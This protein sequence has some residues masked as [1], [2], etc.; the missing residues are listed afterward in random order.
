MLRILIIVSVLLLGGSG[1]MGLIN[2]KDLEKEKEDTQTN[3]GKL[4][5]TKGLLAS[6]TEKLEDAK[7]ARDAAQ[8]ATA[9]NTEDADSLRAKNETLAADLEK[10]KAQLA[11]AKEK[12][13][14]LMGEMKDMPDVEAIAENLNELQTAD[15]KLTQEVADAEAKLK[16]AEE[17]V[18]VVEARLK[19]AE[20]ADSNI[21]NK[22]SPPDLSARLVNVNQALGF[23]IVDAGIDRSVMPDSKLA[24]MRGDRKVAELHVTAVEKS[25]SSADIVPQSLAPGEKLQPGDKVVSVGA[26]IVKIVKTDASGNEI[27]PGATAVGA[28]AD[29]SAD[30]STDSATDSSSDSA[31]GDDTS[32]E[33]TKSDTSTEDDKGSSTEEDPFA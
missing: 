15:A 7:K 14:K 2:S 11:E 25:R 1:Y 20:L 12:Y 16:A 10:A 17:K 31:T 27:K 23:V 9:K 5:T 8:A 21:R 3:Q 33:D 26:S 18:G 6:E 29:S 4:D 22:V 28:A 30:S 32:T 24:V 19:A 13:E